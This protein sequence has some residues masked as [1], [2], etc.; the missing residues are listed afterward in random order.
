MNAIDKAAK[1][2]VPIER[3]AAASEKISTISTPVV[4]LART[5][6]EIGRSSAPI[7]STGNNKSTR[8][9]RARRQKL[10]RS[11]DPGRPL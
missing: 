1:L 7:L 2:R 8:L 4:R 10:D 11:H 5:L 9:G 3:I 6:E